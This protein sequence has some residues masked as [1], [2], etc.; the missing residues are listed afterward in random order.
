MPYGGTHECYFGKISD[1]GD[2]TE[3]SRWLEWR[4]HG[5]PK[6]TGT[7]NL[8]C[9]EANEILELD[10]ILVASLII[11]SPNQIW[12]NCIR[13]NAGTYQLCSVHIH[14]VGEVCEAKQFVYQHLE[15]KWTKLQSC[16]KTQILVSVEGF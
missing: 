5:C 8:D 4:S 16:M 6:V 13:N 9:F 11:G 7:T 15:M 2:Q 1:Y 10:C 12:L 3:R 14:E